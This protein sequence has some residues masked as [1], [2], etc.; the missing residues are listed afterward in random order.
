MIQEKNLKKKFKQF[1][2]SGLKNPNQVGVYVL[3]NFWSSLEEDFYR[4][5][6]LRSMG[7]MP[8]VMIYDKQKYVNSRGRWLDGVENKFTK[9]QLLHF[10]TVQHMQRWCGNRKLI[11]VSPNFNDYEPYKNWVKKGMQVPYI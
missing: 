6:T 7:F 1:K 4:I 10:K 5:Y 3:T 2:D 11:K 9:E 8:F